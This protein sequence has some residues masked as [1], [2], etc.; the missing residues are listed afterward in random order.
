[1]ARQGDIGMGR[2]KLGQLGD[3]VA[4]GIDLRHH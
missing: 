3:Q 2:Y 4:L 1:M